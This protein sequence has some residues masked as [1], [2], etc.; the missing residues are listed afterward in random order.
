MKIQVG[1]R[2]NLLGPMP[3]VLVGVSVNGKPNYTTVAYVGIFSRNSVSVAMSKARYGNASIKENKTFSV[4]IPS[5]DMV[6]Q[7]DYCGIVSG[8]KV[9][10]SGVF[11][12]FYGELQ[13]AP[14]IEECPVN[15]ECRVV[16][17]LR[18]GSHD[19]IIGQIEGAYASEDCI[20]KG[21]PDVL[22]IK[23]IIFD[24]DFRRYFAF[25]EQIAES[26]KVGLELRKK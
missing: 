3:I 4:N 25:G 12:T 24:I 17:I 10:K 18:L 5:A 6:V 21:F 23:P 1:P 20:T 16:H 11:T 13:T 15:L 14:M 8:N 22:K 7:T 19:L 2:K 9:D 26:H